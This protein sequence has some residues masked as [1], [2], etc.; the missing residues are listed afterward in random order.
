MTRILCRIC[1]F[2]E[3]MTALV[4]NVWTTCL[5]WRQGVPGAPLPTECMV[6]MREPGADDE[7]PFVRLRGQMPT[8][9]AIIVAS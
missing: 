3:P 9:Y 7:W 8:R 4:A 6:F 5:H 2:G 1:R